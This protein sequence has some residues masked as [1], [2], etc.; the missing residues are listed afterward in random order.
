VAAPLLVYERTPASL[1]RCWGTAELARKAAVGRL[2][3]SFCEQ[4]EFGFNSAFEPSLSYYDSS[5][6]NEQSHSPVFRDHLERVADLAIAAY[7]ER[8]RAI[9][10]IGCGQGAFL[11]LLARKLGPRVRLA[12]L[13]PACRAPS[14][15]GEPMR[16]LARRLDQITVDDLPGDPSLLY[17]RHVI[18]HIPRPVEFLRDWGRLNPS[19][20][21]V[22]IL[23]E[24][25]SLEWILQNGAYADFLYEHCSYFSE[26]ALRR[27][28]ARAGFETCSVQRMFGAQYSV[29]VART[30][31]DRT[32]QE[33]TPAS[34]RHAL[35]RFV[36]AESEYRKQWSDW[37][38]EE[39][40]GNRLA[41]WGGGAKGVSFV[42]LHDP[43]ANRIEC[44]IDINPQKQGRF[45][46]V[47]GHP[48]VAPEEA[49]R[50]GI[51]AAI[52]MNPNYFDEIRAI[53]DAMFAKMNLIPFQVCARSG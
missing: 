39:A 49:A 1:N 6:E 14:G 12:G 44:V 41:V 7:A 47:T 33:P 31:A 51:T 27:L 25:P 50:R 4:C 19:C 43:D 40:R 34:V 11:R 23:L 53:V 45:I 17:S 37:I 22:A 5:Y 48:I 20:R 35:E 18:E 46:P 13:D 8:D 9:V 15:P 30:G 21:D 10:E 36:E 38:A 29:A 28:L 52:V 32:P 3:L 16:L 26:T 42:S 24:T 2:E